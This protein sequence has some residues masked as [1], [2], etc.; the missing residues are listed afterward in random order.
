[1]KKRPTFIILLFSVL[2]FNTSIYAQKK[3]DVA[4]KEQQGHELIFNIEGATDSMIYLAI[5]YKTSLILKDSVQPTSKGKYVFKGET[6]YDEGLYTLVSYN[7]V[8][9]LNFIIDRGQ[10]FEFFLNVKGDPSTFSVKN[11]PH[12]QEV[13]LFQQQASVA[14]KRVELL[15]K[16]MKEF[17]DINQ[18][19]SAEKYRDALITVN[20]EMGQFIED[21]IARNPDYLFSKLQKSYQQIE[22]PDP[23]MLEDGSIDSNFQMIYYRTHYWDN[24]DLSDRRFIYL[25]SIEPK[26]NDYV[27]KVLAY[28]E[29][30]TICRYVDLFLEKVSADS[31]MY[32]FYLDRLTFDF[33]ES[34]IG[35]DAVFAHI[36]RNNQLAGKTPWIDEDLL[37]KFRKRTV[38]IEKTLIGRKATELIIPDTTGNRWYSS[39]Q[40]P[41]KYVILWFYDPTCGTCKSEAKKLHHVYDSLTKAGTRNFEVFAIGN[42]SDED[43]W[44]RYVRDNNYPWI[45]VGGHVANVDYMD[46]Y[47]IVGNPTMFILNDRREIILNKRIDMEMIPEFLRQ[48]EKLEELKKGGK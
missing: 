18:T 31:L 10:H 40:L 17:N 26:Y 22:I 21:L 39:H 30:D 24:F 37:E 2:C 33:Q 43:R 19:D 27:K 5:H 12:N 14:Q 32:R 6:P 36:T 1:M 35:Y 11:S 23:P 45:N 42:D 44:K 41:D 38:E 47:A 7:K 46:A 3:K 28:Q 9:Y 48:Y 34:R 20:E 15:Q 16:K 25:P 4:A 8:P 29:S 13:L